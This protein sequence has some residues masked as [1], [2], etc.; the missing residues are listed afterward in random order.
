MPKKDDFEIGQVLVGRTGHHASVRGKASYTRP[1]K[2]FVVSDERYKYP[3]DTSYRSV[4]EFEAQTGGSYVPVRLPDDPSII[5]KVT[6]PTKRWDSWRSPSGYPYFTHDFVDA[7]Q[8]HDERRK[9]W[10]E[11]GQSAEAWPGKIQSMPYFR[12]MAPSGVIHDDVDAYDVEQWLAAEARWHAQQR[13]E[14]RRKRETQ[15]VEETKERLTDLIQKGHEEFGEDDPIVRLL[16]LVEKEMADPYGSYYTRPG[17][18]RARL[19]FHD[20]ADALLGPE[21]TE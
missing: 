9:A 10:L 17:E 7:V 18:H 20:I 14:E 21:V 5:W 1:R 15:R 16:E 6:V 12:L 19:Y 4:R 11:D 2:Y 8:H 13:K 3:Q